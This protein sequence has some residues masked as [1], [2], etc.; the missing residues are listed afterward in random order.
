M[1]RTYSVKGTYRHIVA[2]AD[3]LTW[4]IVTYNDSETDLIASDFDEMMKGKK[5][6][7]DEGQLVM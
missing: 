5:I 4:K 3:K 7:N 2:R 1:C 6:A